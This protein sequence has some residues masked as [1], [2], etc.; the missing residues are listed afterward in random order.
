MQDMITAGVGASRLVHTPT[1]GVLEKTNGARIVREAG[2][3][4]DLWR[5]HRHSVRVVIENGTVLAD[6]RRQ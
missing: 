1:R 2:V 4:T 5:R 6:H 3:P